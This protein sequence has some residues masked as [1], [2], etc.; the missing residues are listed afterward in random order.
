MSVEAV[1]WSLCWAGPRCSFPLP[2]SVI[3]SVVTAPPTPQIWV[4]QLTGFIAAPSLTSNLPHMVV[5][6]SRMCD[7]F[8]TEKE[9]QGPSRPVQWPFTKCNRS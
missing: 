4:I 7:K 6:T 2:Y 9:N 3:D 8:E 5:M 1:T